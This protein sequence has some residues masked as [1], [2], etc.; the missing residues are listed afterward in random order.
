MGYGRSNDMKENEEKKKAEIEMRGKK[1]RK[2]KVG[3]R[4]TV[5]RGMSYQ[6]Q[7]S[8]PQKGGAIP[9]GHLT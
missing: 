7:V 5:S 2:A 9:H 8:A 3:E 4:E 6:P 1:Q